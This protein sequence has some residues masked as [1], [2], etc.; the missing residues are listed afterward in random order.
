MNLSKI[1]KNVPSLDFG[2]LITMWHNSLSYRDPREGGL[3]RDIVEHEWINR[4]V[5][6]LE[7]SNEIVPEIGL[8]AT[9]GYRVGS[10]RGLNS[11]LRQAILERVCSAE[12]PLVFSHSYMAQWGEPDSWK[13]KRKLQNTLIAFIES[14][15]GQPCFGK[16][17]RDWSE[18]LVYLQEHIF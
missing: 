17:V 12:L 16:A 8:L 13:R 5:N 14:K 9:L 1:R 3:V 7:F 4:E 10:T 2:K 18:D 11:N 15:N 6:L